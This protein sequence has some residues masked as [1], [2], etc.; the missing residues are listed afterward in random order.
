MQ[1]PTFY[2]QHGEDYLAW[3]AL[4]RPG[5]GY[6][7]EIGALDGRRFSNSYAFERLG[8]QGLCVEAHPAYFEHTRRNRPAAT[9]IHAACCDRDGAS[10]VFHANDR[11][12]LSAIE[13][14]DPAFIQDRFAAYFNGFTQIEV[15][16][17]TLTTILA[18]AGAPKR[19]DVVSIDVEG[20]EMQVLRGLDFKAYRPRVLIVEANDAKDEARLSAFLEAAGYLRARRV[21][22]NLLYCDEAAVA[23]RMANQPID[24]PLTH[25]PHPLD[26]DAIATVVPP[27]APAP[28]RFNLRRVRDVLQSFVSP[29]SFRKKI[30]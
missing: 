13:P 16:A 9:V 22:M 12:T 10:I 1:V 27:Q 7:A 29:A 21:A 24:V 17:M 5:A 8:W 30:A 2:S 15:P 23:A 25:T 26:R 28:G 18:R 11:G 20:N 4:G 3:V 6:Y 19:P 14:L